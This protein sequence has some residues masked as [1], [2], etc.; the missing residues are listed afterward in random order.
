LVSS[1]QNTTT[2]ST[3]HNPNTIRFFTNRRVDF[4]SDVRLRSGRRL[5]PLT[6]IFVGS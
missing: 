4:S 3:A 1:H 2:I 6:A 5:A